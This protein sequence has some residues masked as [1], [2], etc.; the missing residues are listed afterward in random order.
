MRSHVYNIFS[1]RGL[2]NVLELYLLAPW[3]AQIFIPCRGICRRAFK[4]C[5]TFAKLN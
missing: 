2:H 5:D 4:H 3:W 1:G